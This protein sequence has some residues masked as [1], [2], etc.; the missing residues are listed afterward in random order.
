MAT[1][2]DYHNPEL[3]DDDELIDPDDGAHALS[4]FFL[5]S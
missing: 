4:V 3:E 1:R 5:Y 2:K